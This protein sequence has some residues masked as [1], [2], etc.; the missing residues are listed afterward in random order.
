MSIKILKTF[1]LLD[2]CYDVSSLIWSKNSVLL[3][4]LFG[5]QPAETWHH[6]LT[7][8]IHGGQQGSRYE[9]LHVF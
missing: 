1:R 4:K 2:N 9:I 7:N 3:E 5:G 6:R 8:W